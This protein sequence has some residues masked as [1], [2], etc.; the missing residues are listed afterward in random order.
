MLA[1]PAASAPTI[2]IYDGNRMVRE[3]TGTNEAG[4]NQVVWDMDFGRERTAEETAAM[5]AGGGRGGFG[6]GGF[7]GRGGANPN[8]PPTNAYQPAPEGTYPV[9]MVVDGQEFETTATILEDHWWDKQF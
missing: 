6:G 4:L 5:R 1:S 3:L 9:V 8:R 7:R 2:R